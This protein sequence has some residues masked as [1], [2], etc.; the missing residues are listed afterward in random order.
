MTK[1]PVDYT[2]ITT[3]D[4]TQFDI[5]EGGWWENLQVE[6]KT[7]EEKL[8]KQIGTGKTSIRLDKNSGD[9]TLVVAHVSGYLVI[10]RQ[11]STTH[12][13]YRISKGD[14]QSTMVLLSAGRKKFEPM[15]NARS[16]DWDGLN[17][18]IYSSETKQYLHDWSKD[19]VFIIHGKDRMQPLLL[20]KFLSKHGINAIV[21]DDLS[22]KG[23]TIMEQIEYIQNNVSFAFAILTPDDIGCLKEN[24][25]RI[26]VEK[27]PS[28][29]TLSKVLGSL[30]G[31][32]RQNVLFEMGLFMGA[33]G[34][35]NVRFLKQKSLKDIPS[36]IDGVLCK[37]FD[38]TVEENF[39][40]LRDELHL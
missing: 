4:W 2:I 28:K 15:V 13:K 32:A 31:R 5:L 6:C 40:E 3:S 37:Y 12:L 23:R 38:K 18:V 27:S 25:D 14:R 20:H 1:V 10:R 29:D 16:D 26:M 39:D 11:S 33:L 17:P 22:D 36:D 24:I 21:F 9:E 19:K 35:E 34:R 30:E 7:G 8:T